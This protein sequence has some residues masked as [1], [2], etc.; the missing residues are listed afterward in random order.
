M[1]LPEITKTEVIRVEDG[2]VL[3]VFIKGH[4][5]QESLERLKQELRNKFLPKKIEVA[6]INADVVDLKVLR[7]E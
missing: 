5:T 2:D 6:I 7:A 3:G 4:S 1:D